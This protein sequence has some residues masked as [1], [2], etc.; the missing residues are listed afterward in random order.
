[1]EHLIQEKKFAIKY[2]S[3]IDNDEVFSYKLVDSKH[4]IR[5]FDSEESAKEYLGK[6]L[7]YCHPYNQN[8]K[9]ISDFKVTFRYK[10]S[11]EEPELLPN[12]FGYEIVEI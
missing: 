11:R 3:K 5:E 8:L 10:A 2:S 1:M 12:I 9:W 6:T 7:E 4:N